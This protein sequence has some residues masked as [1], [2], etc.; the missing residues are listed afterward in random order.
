MLRALLPAARRA[1]GAA[2]LLLAVACGGKA[3]PGPSPAPV[4]ATPAPAAATPSPAS[5]PDGPRRDLR[6]DE[7]RGG[8]TIARHVARSDAELL[9]RLRRE[10][11]ISAASTYTDLATAE[12][13]VGATLRREEA[14]LL[15]WLSRQGRRPDL[16]LDYRGEGEPVGRSLR[17]G[18]RTPA[19]CGS[20]TVV[21]RWD[22]RRGDWYVLTSYPEANP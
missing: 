1:S 21:L 2:A 16:V 19:R 11:R 4:P 8:H 7:T 14:R 18:A 17:R 12:R 9:E 5:A 20:A 3:E 6:A 10:K 13:V 22:E 15:R